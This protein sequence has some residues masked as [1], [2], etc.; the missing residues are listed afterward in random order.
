MVQVQAGVGRTGKWWGH[1]HVSGEAVEPDIM[2]FA[3]GIASGF[4]FAGLATRENMFEGLATG[5]MGGTYGVLAFP[6]QFPISD[7]SDGMEIT[8]PTC[9]KCLTFAT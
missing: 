4:P 5:T 9:S 1:Q 3:K 8:F 2:L 6:A 7:C